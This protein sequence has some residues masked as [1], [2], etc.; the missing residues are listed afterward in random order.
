M[1]HNDASVIARHTVTL[2]RTKLIRKVLPV[3]SESSIKAVLPFPVVRESQASMNMSTNRFQIAPDI[4]I[5]SALSIV[6]C[7]Y[8]LA[9]NIGALK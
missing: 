2:A 4:C 6:F 8:S 1:I 5:F 9:K 7:R 3:S